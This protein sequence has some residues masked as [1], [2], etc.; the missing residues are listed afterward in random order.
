MK[1]FAAQHHQQ[2]AA[3]RPCR[4]LGEADDQQVAAAQDHEHRVRRGPLCFPLFTQDETSAVEDVR[5]H[6]VVLLGIGEHEPRASIVKET[7]HGHSDEQRGQEETNEK[8]W[9]VAL[10]GFSDGAH[11]AR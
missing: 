7:N 1:K 3:Q 11:G 5:R 2:H 10:E 4:S 8:V 9:L 6:L